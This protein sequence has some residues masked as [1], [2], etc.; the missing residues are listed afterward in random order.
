V[1][2]SGVVPVHLGTLRALDRAL[3][4]DVAQLDRLVLSDRAAEEARQVV[5]RFQRFHVGVELRSQRFL[6]RMGLGGPV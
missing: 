1:R 4:L 5:G 2:R 3:A 6:D